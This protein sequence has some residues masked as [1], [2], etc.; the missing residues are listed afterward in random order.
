MLQIRQKVNNKFTA[1]TITVEQAKCT[2]MLQ[3]WHP[4]FG[5]QSNAIIH[6]VV[7]SKYLK[8]MTSWTPIFW[9]PPLFC[10]CSKVN[11][12]SWWYLHFKHNYILFLAGEI[13]IVLKY[14]MEEVPT[15]FKPVSR[16]LNYDSIAV[17][18]IVIA[19]KLLLGF[20]DF[21]ER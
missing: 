12:Y 21:R 18:Y 14:L 16:P 19:L 17:A 9:L 4:F 10:F 6:T 11:G 1:N 2:Q 13:H 3:A 20:D 8:S 5:S 7:Q 15:E